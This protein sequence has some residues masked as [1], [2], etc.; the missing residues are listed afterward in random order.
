MERL[1][2]LSKNPNDEMNQREIEL[3][4]M[5][6]QEINASP[7]IL[8]RLSEP[9]KS[10]IKKALAL[11]ER[12]NEKIRDIIHDNVKNLK[13][14][15]LRE[16]KEKI[17]RTVLEKLH[18]PFD[19]NN[20]IYLRIMRELDNVEVSVRNE[21]LKKSMPVPKKEFDVTTKENGMWR[22]ARLLS[23]IDNS[24]L[25]PAEQDEM[26]KFIADYY[27]LPY[28]SESDRAQIDKYIQKMAEVYDI[29]DK[30]VN[31]KNDTTVNALPDEKKPNIAIPMSSRAY[32]DFVN[33]IK[34]KDINREESRIKRLA[35]VLKD[36][37]IANAFSS[38]SLSETNIIS[39]GINTFFQKTFDIA[40][41]YWKNPLIM[42]EALHMMAKEFADVSG[43]REDFINYV[44]YT[45]ETYGAP[46]TFGAQRGV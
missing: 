33:F 28:F 32:E 10:D 23:Y 1:A 34:S 27:G 42:F 30:T 43:I 2:E 4:N 13:F 17:A 45:R 38:I 3:I 9:L 41:R 44:M 29:I 15:Q 14:K 20:P 24:K 8:N 19:E 26:I 18:I 21:L 35:A 11:Y 37:M 7:D 40:L 5:A 36:L 46:F 12:E 31:I 25:S 6:L 16:N 22:L 39:T